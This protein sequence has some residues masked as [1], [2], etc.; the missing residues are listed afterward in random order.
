LQAYLQSAFGWFNCHLHAFTIDGDEYGPL[1]PDDFAFGMEMLDE[2]DVTL[3]T[4]IAESGRKPRWIYA[5]DFGDDWRHEIRFE[6]F[7]RADPKV[8][9]PLCVAGERACPPED[10]GGPWGYA[11]LVEAISD[12]KHPRHNEL[13]EW[14]GPFDP[15]AFD[16]KK[17]TREMRKDG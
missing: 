3:G 2:E 1:V 9:Y 11:G 17:A 15:E 14:T 6:G 16:V 7:V 5:Y 12:P 13:L 10:C 8:K 4:L